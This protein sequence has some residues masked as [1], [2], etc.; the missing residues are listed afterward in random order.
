[1][2]SSTD[3]S[4]TFEPRLDMTVQKV[5]RATKLTQGR[6]VQPD[7]SAQ[8]DYPNGV[9]AFKNQIL[10]EGDPPTRLPGRVTPV[11]SCALNSTGTASQRG[12]R[13]TV[14]RLFHSFKGRGC[15]FLWIG[16]APVACAH[17]TEC[18]PGDR[19]A[20]TQG[21]LIFLIGRA[22]GTG[23][24]QRTGR[25][26]NRIAP[27]P[28]PESRSARSSSPTRSNQLRPETPGLRGPGGMDATGMRSSPNRPA[29]FP[30]ASSK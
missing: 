1:M 16:D 4:S 23:Y 24:R 11:L 7:F 6:I 3:R 26:L 13:R 2:G 19:L 22:S 5:G 25:S 21:E 29:S 27:R 9:A 15:N 14:V 17:G 18:G 12:S 10:I 20:A 28:A 8:V 30:N